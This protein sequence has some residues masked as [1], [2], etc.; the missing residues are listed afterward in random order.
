[1]IKDIHSLPVKGLDGKSLAYTSHKWQCGDELFE[2]ARN[3][4]GYRS[5]DFQKNPKFIFAGCSETF[6]ESA[7]YETTW[8]YKLFNK[9]KSEDDVYCNIGLPGLDI[10]LVIYHVFL[11]IEKYG[12]PETIFMLAPQFNRLIETH[13]DKTTTLMLSVD[14]EDGSHKMDNIEYVD[15]RVIDAVR[16]VNLLQIKSF[17]EFCRLSNINLIW[18]TWCPESNKKV[19][20]EQIFNN[21]INI[22]VT[23]D[24]A[25]L[26]IELGYDVKNIKVSRSDGNH[27]G[28]VFHDHWAKLF[29]SEY[30]KRKELVND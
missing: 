9:I 4:D 21:Y 25:D 1:M 16:S 5:E 22:L 12:K 20:K 6:G 18:G 26:A 27:H 15:E 24:I 29:N 8:A 3:S 28:E 30:L 2:Y 11:F 10:S 17:E 7:E 19:Q 14:P 13:K 23:K